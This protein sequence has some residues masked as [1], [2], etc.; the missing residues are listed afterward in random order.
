MAEG[1]PLVFAS[2]KEVAREAE[3]LPFADAMSRIGK[4]Q[5][6]TVDVLYGSED[7]MEGFRAFAEKRAPP[8]EGKIILPRN[9]LRR[10]RKSAKSDGAN[11]IGLKIF[12]DVFAEFKGA[13]DMAANGAVDEL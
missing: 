4:R 5:F 10:E 2:V 11:L 7:N 9:Q 13:A 1:P 8:V 3:A 12:A 6:R